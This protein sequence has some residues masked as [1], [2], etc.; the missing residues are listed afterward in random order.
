MNDLHFPTIVNL[1]NDSD[2]YS[3][4]SNPTSVDHGKTP[5][6]SAEREKCREHMPQAT[7]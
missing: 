4:S 1:K 6:S 7:Q 3:A 2:L 5:G